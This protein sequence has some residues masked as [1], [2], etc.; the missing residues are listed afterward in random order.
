MVKVT[1]YQNKPGIWYYH[2]SPMRW[3]KFRNSAE[4]R[5]MVLFNFHFTGNRKKTSWNVFRP[6]ALPCN[7]SYSPRTS[8]IV[9]NHCG[10]QEKW[11]ITAMRSLFSIW[12]DDSSR[13][14]VVSRFY[15]SSFANLEK[16][17]DARTWCKLAKRAFWISRLLC[18]VLESADEFPRVKFEIYE[19]EAVSSW[20]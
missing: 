1:Y 8:S 3:I 18:R 9:A 4:F 2:A 12:A 7:C 20:N 6:N 16:F 15:G 17:D 13:W 14:C 19:S 10:T 5:S 11:L